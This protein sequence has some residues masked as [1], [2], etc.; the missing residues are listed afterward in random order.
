MHVYRQVVV[1]ICDVYVAPL[2][3]EYTVVMLSLP[4]LFNAGLFQL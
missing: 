3:P 1:I 4:H 2:V